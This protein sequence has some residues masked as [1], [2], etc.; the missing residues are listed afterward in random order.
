LHI[1]EDGATRRIRLG[2]DLASG[3]IPQAIVPARAWQAA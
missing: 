3:E 2:P 1:A